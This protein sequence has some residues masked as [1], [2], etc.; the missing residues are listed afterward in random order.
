MPYLRVPRADRAALAKLLSLSEE[1]MGKLKGALKK[2]PPAL[3]LDDLAN[4]IASETNLPKDD[5]H[6][7]V[8][9]LAKL[10]GIRT[11]Q[12]VPIPE[13]AADVC[14][15]AQEANLK[16]QEGL[17]WNRFQSDLTELLSFEV[18]LGITSKALEVMRQ[19]QK[20][21][22]NA[23]ILSDLRP[24]FKEQVDEGPA[25]AVIIHNL[26]IAYHAPDDIEEF[27]VAMSRENLLNLRAVIERALKKEESLRK[28]VD[29]ISLPF[30]D[31]TD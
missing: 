25:A 22:C 5:T 20:V 14:H 12:A 30:L 23:R 3:L 10:Y 17:D 21:F 9:L 2:A 24:V 11:R 8:N 27:F 18:S 6:E 28:F 16:P 13:F 4:R 31:Q 15:A 19:H 1:E 7:M 26:R 29:S